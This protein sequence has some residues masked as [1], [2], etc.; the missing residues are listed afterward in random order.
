[1]TWKYTS[2]GCTTVTFLGKVSDWKIIYIK[3]PLPPKVFAQAN[4]VN[5]TNTELIPVSIWT[6]SIKLIKVEQTIVRAETDTTKEYIVKMSVCL[7]YLSR[8]LQYV[9]YAINARAGIES[10]RST[11]IGPANATKICGAELFNILPCCVSAR[12]KG[13]KVKLIIIFE[14]GTFWIVIGGRI[15]E[16]TKVNT[17]SAF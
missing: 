1:M 13:E 12:I 16:Y 11:G 6:S 17:F 15:N 9:A 2:H 7:I 8:I 5:P 10:I 14:N 4:T 3:R